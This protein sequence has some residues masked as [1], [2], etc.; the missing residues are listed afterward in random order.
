M[1]RRLYNMDIYT[2]QQLASSDAEALRTALGD[3][4]RRAKCEDWIEQAA[5][6]SQREGTVG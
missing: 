4:G 3:I 6:L 1:Q 2:Y 5:A